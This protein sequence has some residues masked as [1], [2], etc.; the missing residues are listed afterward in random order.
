MVALVINGNLE[1][2]E[3]VDGKKINKT[4]S[5]TPKSVE[6]LETVD[7]KSAFVGMLL[8]GY[9]KGRFIRMETAELLKKYK[10]LF[11]VDPEDVLHQVLSKRINKIEKNME[12]LKEAA[13]EEVKN[14][15][16]GSFLKLNRMYEEIVAENEGLENKNAIT[17]NIL[18]KRTGC[19]NQSIRKWIRA[20]KERLDAYHQSI[21]ITDPGNHNRLLGVIKRV[22]R[23]KKARKEKEAAND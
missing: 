3:E 21:G 22:A 5:L 8:E 1:V 2:F 16:G 13:P 7:R 15:V 17:F 10:A 11:G 9:Q 19:N 6:F 4:F 20:N 14:K 18:F 23:L 12:A